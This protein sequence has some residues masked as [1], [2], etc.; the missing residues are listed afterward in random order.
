MNF[1]LN[2]IRKKLG[3]E[4]NAVKIFG[5]KNAESL[6]GT[7]V[8]STKE[9]ALNLLS[10]GPDA[11]LKSNDPFIKFAVE[12]APRVAEL[13]KKN[14]ELRNKVEVN[15]ELIGRAAFEVY[16]TS[17]PPDATFTLRISDGVIKSY[18]YNGT[19]APPKTTFYGYYDRYYSFNKQYPF[20]LPERWIN[21]P[22]EFDKSTPFNFI[23]TCD[24]IGGNSGSPV[25]NK[26]AEIIGLAFD[27][28][29]ESLD[30]NYIY[31][32]DVPHTV[33][34][35]SEGMF[36]ALQDL[37]KLKRISEELRTGKLYTE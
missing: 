27:G 31:N 4:N 25:I 19:I 34:V 21:P 35:D 20:D 12:S 28:N 7:S 29:I 2:A 32:T 3:N 14:D 8:L 22:A 16:G 9:G 10:Q 36:E 11:I 26:D 37:Y 6:A 15:K 5:N 30:D 18:E 23:S 1:K 33:S 17:I 13:K 24:I